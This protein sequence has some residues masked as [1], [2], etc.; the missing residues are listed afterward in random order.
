DGTTIALSALS[1]DV[2]AFGIFL[3]DVT[4]G[5][6]PR[7]LDTGSL[8]AATAAWSP[9]GSRIAF[10]SRGP[11]GVE[12]DIYVVDVDGGHLTRLT[13]A[14]GDDGSPAWSPDGT[15]IAFVSHRDGN[16]ELYVMAAD[17]S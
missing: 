3:Y 1:F 11:E 12:Y 10:A 5:S 9:D 13:R 17:G 15:R 2:F 14:P 4:G 7:M 6:V 16:A 8:G